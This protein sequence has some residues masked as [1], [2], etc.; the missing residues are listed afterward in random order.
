MLKNIPLFD[1]RFLFTAAVV[2]GF[3]MLAVLRPT[4]LWLIA[5]AGLVCLAIFVLTKIPRLLL[6]IL[7]G[8]VFF[9]YTLYGT[10]LSL[11]LTVW[12]ELFILIFFISILLDKF[13]S[14]RL[15][16][17]RSPLDGAIL[18]FFLTCILSFFL[19]LPP[20]RVGLEGIRN[21]FFYA[22]V[23]FCIM[24]CRMNKETLESTIHVII[25][26][27]LLQIPVLGYQ[28]LQAFINHEPIS[29]DLFQGTFPGANNLSYAT[30]FPIFLF[31]GLN[32]F[33]IKGARNILILLGLLV[34]LILGQGRLSILLFPI[35]IIGL[36]HK[37]IFTFRLSKTFLILILIFTVG[38]VSYFSL[39]SKKLMNDYN[40]W[41][42][43]TRAEFNVH[44]G[45]ARYLYYPLTWNL[46][47]KSGTSTLLFGFGPGMYGSLASFK[48]STPLSNLLSN[49]FGQRDCGLDPYVSSEI[50]PIWGELGF[51]GL[52]VFLF[53]LWR[54]FTFAHSCYKLYSQPL[55]RSLACGLFASSSLMIIGSFFNPVYEVQVLAYPFWL[56]AGLLVR[57]VRMKKKGELA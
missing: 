39:T 55:I 21:Y 27:F 29:P 34:V 30:L 50:I 2:V 52:L 3:S 43:F 20:L 53:L 51:V 10:P 32:D 42:I 35:I 56:I 57:A 44:S 49:A 23:F 40:L 16:F 9:Q 11:Y 26:C 22:L 47:D 48:Y 28:I 7:T 25:G 4:P 8:I 14:Q 31:L 17:A 24:N 13:R 6:G 45:S 54:F 38:I 41:D 18:A 36:F 12:D 46:L 33:K 15:L 37:N 19:N 5:P 1:K